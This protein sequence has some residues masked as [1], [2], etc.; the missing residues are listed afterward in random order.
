MNTPSYGDTD[1][2]AAVAT[3]L[4][5]SALTLIR[6]SGEGALELLAKVFSR[7]EKLRKAGGNTLV[8]GWI[9]GAQ[10]ERIDDVLVSVY[11]GPAAFTGEDGADVCC[12]GGIAAAKAVMETLGRAG[13]REALRGEFSFR[14]FMNGKLDLTRA[15]SIMEIVAA[16]T[17]RAREHAVH[18]L[19]GA[20]EREIRE[21]GAG[22][23]R[24][25]AAAEICLDYSEDDG[26]GGDEEA[27]LLP[28]RYVVVEALGRL[29]TLS[30]SYRRERLYAQGALAVIAGRPNA[31]KSSLFNA[32][33]RED[34]AIVTDIPGTT[35]DWIEAWVSIEG[36][37][38]RLADTA[39]LHPSEDPVEKLG[40][41]RSRE[42]LA[43][44]DLVLYV[45]DGAEGVTEDDRAFLS[46]H[47]GDTSAAPALA[48]WNKADL[49]P[50]PPSFRPVSAKTGEGIAELA[51]EIAT[52]LER[53]LGGGDG[54]NTAG[55]G[56]ERQKALVDRGIA[57]LEEALSLADRREPLD[58]IAPALREAVNA[59]G[60]ITGEVST[61][62][63][64][65]VMFSRFCVG[66]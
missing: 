43:A 22:L 34:R 20:L 36:I 8:H 54:G 7:P 42:L 35:R 9:L 3:A 4:G 57:A 14:A 53:S 30:D 23:V 46:D 33:L 63:L 16:K 66:K 17:G 61:A 51:G 10:G 18:R 29:K 28:D 44:A 26:V 12:H 5:E 40:M 47:G 27:G 1:P 37:P 13:F 24:A 62:E 55:A 49:A 39:G 31:G 50:P 58:L 48:L 56:T 6:T 21:I 15:E 2:I 64:L 45:L 59:L 25:L 19:S 32:L 60:E 11:R 41:E 65:D 52:V 38:V